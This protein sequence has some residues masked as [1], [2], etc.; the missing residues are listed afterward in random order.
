MS[1]ELHDRVRDLLA[2]ASAELESVAVCEAAIG[3]AVESS[4]LPEIGAEAA[5]I[6]DETN[7]HDLIEGLGMEDTDKSTTIPKAIMTG[8][9]A[10]VRDLRALVLLSRLSSNGDPETDPESTLERTV[11][12][13]H[14]TFDRSDRLRVPA[15]DTRAGVKSQA[16]EGTAVASPND[17]QTDRRSDQAEPD[18][19]E[20]TDDSGSE[21]IRSA[22]S[23]AMNELRSDVEGMHEELGGLVADGTDDGEEAGSKTNLE[24]EETDDPSESGAD[25]D[26]SMAAV[27]EP[28]DSGQLLG[29]NDSSSGG[30]N[31]STVAT[32]ERADMRAVRRYSTMPDR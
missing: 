21:A 8:D 24:D 18:R 12:T 6:L 15:A 29:E 25:A 31:V 27:A 26:E 7:P 30:S 17:E 16:E 22:L 23:S 5:E 4:A 13:L 11:V 28:A 9:S 32:R 19:E 14:Q 2:E 10:P 3:P 20:S 1:T